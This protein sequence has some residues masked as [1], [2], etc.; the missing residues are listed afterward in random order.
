MKC[1]VCNFE[2]ENKKSFSNHVRYGCR[3]EV[4][5]SSIKC[6]FC[7][8]FI[9]KRKPSEIGMFCNN[10]CYFKW[11]KGV[12]LGP[13]KERV[14]IS[15]YYYVMMPN[16]KRANKRGYVP[17]HIILVEKS[18]K[19]ELF[20]NETVHHIDHNSLNNNID[21]LKLM[22]IHDHLSYHAIEKHKKSKGKKWKKEQFYFEENA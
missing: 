14:L 11:K 15:N 6:K 18:I 4:K 1:N 16:H 5:K 20:D 7:G 3:L 22:T 13:R 17:E 10:K 19:R 21:N 2:T 9:P 8:E 12:L